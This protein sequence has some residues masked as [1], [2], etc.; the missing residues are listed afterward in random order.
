[1]KLMLRGPLTDFTGYGT[2]GILLAREW[3]KQT[4][5]ALFPTQVTMGLPKEVLEILAQEEPP[6]PDLFVDFTDPMSANG[7]FG[8]KFSVLFTMWEQ[9]KMVV[10]FDPRKLQSYDLMLVPN[11]VNKDTFAEFFPVEKIKIVSL[12]V[13][14]SFYTWKPRKVRELPKIRFCAV[15]NLSRRKGIELIVDAYQKIRSEYENCSLSIRSTGAGLHPRWADIIQDCYMYFGPWS[16]QTLR[17]F[18]Y[19]MDVMLSLTRGEGFNL[20]AV[21]FLATGGTVIATNFMGHAQWANSEYM[22]QVG[23]TVE[24]VK[25][26]YQGLDN[27]SEWGEPNYEEILTAMRSCMDDRETLFQKMLNAKTVAQMFNI[28][29]ITSKIL[30]VVLDEYS[31]YGV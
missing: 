23:H 15:G 11:Q 18:Y 30:E 10:D 31:K 28:E 14:T 17:D 8:K 19:N 29:K 20:P 4:D 25:I 21:E 13:D 9:T 3:S 6:K 1:M 24:K 26:G 22:Y 2:F 7:K 16:K 5:L 27:R 12:G